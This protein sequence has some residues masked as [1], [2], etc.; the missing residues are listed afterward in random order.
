MVMYASLPGSFGVRRTSLLLILGRACLLMLPLILLLICSVR[1]GSVALRFLCLGTLFQLLACGLL[2]SQQ[3]LRESASAVIIMLYGIAL[4]W[5]V[6]GTTGTEDWFSHLAQAVLLVV[7]LVYLAVLCLLE[8]GAPALRRA[9]QLAQ[10]IE[11]RH[12]WPGK[13]SDC[14][15]LPEVQALREA[16]HG[17]AAPALSLLADPRPQVRL[18]ALAALEFRQ[19]WRPGQ[20]Q[21]ILQLAQRAVE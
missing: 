14:R 21:I 6:L 3:G 7:P 2:L 17:E 4:S 16:V 19:N 10:Q 8:S 11:Q 9:R 1:G 12:D 18:A 13:L 15:L 5:L 20:P